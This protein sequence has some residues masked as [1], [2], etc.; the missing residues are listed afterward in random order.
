[1]NTKSK[2][3]VKKFRK[4]RS[5]EPTKTIPLDISKAEIL[6]LPKL[7]FEKEPLPEERIRQNWDVYWD[8]YNKGLSHY[9]RKWYQ[10]AKEEFL[11]IYDG[12]HSSNAYFTHLIRTYRKVINKFI[13]KKKYTEAFLEN[14]EMFSKCPNVTNT[15]IRRYNKLVDFIEKANLDLT[16]SK[17]ELIKKV[18]SEPEPE[19]TFDSNFI[20]YITECK[21]PRGFKIPY[22]DEISVLRLSDL[23]D[24]IPSSLSHIFF[25][26]SDVEYITLQTL[27]T[28]KHD[29][30][31]FRES[32]GRNGFIVSSRDLNIYAYNRNLNLLHWLDVSEYSDGH[33]HLRRVDLSSDF[34]HFLFTNVDKV[35]LLDSMFRII[36]SWEVPHREGWEKRKGRFG[37]SLLDTKFQQYLN[38]LELNENPSKEEI[39][40]SFRRLAHKYHPDKNPDEP[41][42]KSRMIQIIEAYEY[43]ASEEAQKAFK[44]LEDEDS[45][46]NTL[47]T[48]K[49]E[50]GEMSFE[51]GISFG[52][53][54][55]DWIYGSGVSDDA[56]RIYLG[57]YSGKTYQVNKKGVAEK[58]YIIP[59][60]KEGIYGQT[61]PVTYIIERDEYL[62][63]LTYWYLYILKS[64]KVINFIKIGEGDIKWFEY[65][66][67]HQ[68]K[69]NI[70]LYLNNGD[71][72][73][74]IN[75]KGSI[76][77]VCYK[78][79]NLLVETNRK[80]F[81]FKLKI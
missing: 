26:Y 30:Y 24:L 61:N 13:E 54:G 52:D 8:R 64:D 70:F 39:K 43:L 22:S 36:S 77:H 4:S 11:K 58:I 27:P 6:Y 33:T 38:I 19:F 46:V 48:I 40:S 51:I 14:Q 5:R 28:L 37:V 12:Y 15:D 74:S 50:V 49:F 23:S 80:A 53:S 66:F 71:L 62:H 10:K 1:M 31:R 60:D 76:R 20:E 73:G 57:C 59:E 44:G 56:S 7:K 45:W 78:D 55:E 65:G 42:A 2:Y 16:I 9:N 25:N 34:S 68:I 35:Y 32:T 18:E 63:F 79:D 69:D 29:V 67:I 21:K 47:N 72:L 17:I 41:L 3:I 75:F 81:L